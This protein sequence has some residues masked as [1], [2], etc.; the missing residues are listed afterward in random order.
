MPLRLSILVL[1]AAAIGY[2]VLLI[3]LFSIIQWQQFA[4]MV[5]SL[6]LLGY[7][8]SGSVLSLVRRRVQA[9]G[10][11]VPGR[12]MVLAAASFAFLSVGAFLVAQRLPFNPLALVWDPLQLI[13]LLLLYLV[14]SL[15]FFSV[16]FSIGLALTVWREDIAFFYQADL[17]GAGLGAAG[18]VFLLW[19]TP[20]E[21]CLVWIAVAGLLAAT[22]ASL[23][24]RV[25]ARRSS[26]L[27]LA[28]ASVLLMTLPVGWI[29]LQSSEYKSLSRALLV[30]GAEILTER[31]SPLALLS[32]VRNRTVPLRHAPGLSLA[33]EGTLPDQ[34][35]IFSDGEG[36]SA[37]D[38][39]SP[40]SGSKE[41]R[42]L[43]ISSLAYVFATN[44][45]VLVLG[46]GGGEGIVTALGYGAESVTVIERNRHAVD[47]LE[48]ELA[49]FSGHLL[50][51]P[52]V[53]V[54]IGDVRGFLAAHGA[55]WDLI[56]ITDIQSATV[57]SGGVGSAGVNYLYTV[58]AF[59][60]L[61]EHLSPG[62]LLSVTRSLS[63]PPRDSLKLFATAWQAVEQLGGRIHETGS[64]WREAGMR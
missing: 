19:R 43:Q 34:L 32:V 25:A 12:A 11:A 37:L 3:R 36:L 41:Y 62:G 10:E 22:V 53:T 56:Q 45:R 8:A 54:A 47:L 51:E 60:E 21:R 33:Y 1:S 26:T 20:P 6:A 40:G 23:D 48:N 44:P 31:S 13:W 9:S 27:I 17:L 46:L 2:E 52:N 50:S 61:V 49:S 14:L 30:P 58:E 38:R 57:S 28:G 39:R 64:P 55:T 29:R 16:G 15:P 63:L 24:S 18:V 42:D 59:A 35:G 5:I 4:A 7:G